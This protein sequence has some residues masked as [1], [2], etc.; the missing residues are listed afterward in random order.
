MNKSV[1]CDGTLVCA[2]RLMKTDLCNNNFWDVT[3]AC[4][5]KL[6]NLG[7]KFTPTP[8]HARL[9]PNYNITM[10][11]CGVGGSGVTLPGDLWP[12]SRTQDDSSLGTWH[13]A[14]QLIG[15]MAHS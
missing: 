4:E 3:L 13:T 6:L 10:R 5:Y 11:K 15:H 2:H 8:A 14:T 1:V 9:P 7:I 12:E